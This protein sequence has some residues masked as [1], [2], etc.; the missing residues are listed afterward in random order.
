MNK[1]LLGFLFSTLILGA[2]CGDDDSTSIASDPSNDSQDALIKGIWMHDLANNENASDISVVFDVDEG[3]ISSEIIIVVSK[4]SPNTPITSTHLE[5]LESN[6][7]STV[8]IGN[9]LSYIVQ[10]NEAQLDSD[11]DRLSHDQA[12]IIHI[13]APASESFY[14]AEDFLELSNNQI[15]QARYSGE[16]GDNLFDPKVISGAIE[17]TGNNKYEGPAYLESDY[18]PNFGAINDN[19][20]FEMTIVDGQITDFKYTQYAPGY[21]DGCPG[22]YTGTGSIDDNFSI[23]IDFTG[24]DCDGHHED[25]VMIL[26]RNWKE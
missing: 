5:S 20:S 21:R 26:H 15:Y 9:E 8:T 7:Y 13:Y 23:R 12:Y 2:S 18:S 11:G 17:A 14:S 6:L 3:N 4:Q 16:W 19:G 24:D 10:L 1:V 22:L 25:G